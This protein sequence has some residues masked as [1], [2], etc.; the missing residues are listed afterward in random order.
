MQNTD[1]DA[2]IKTKQKEFSNDVTEC[3]VYMFRAMTL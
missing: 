1:D 2:I 3:I